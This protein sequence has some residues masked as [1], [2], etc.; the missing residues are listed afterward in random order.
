MLDVKGIH[1]G[2]GQAMI[3]HDIS[4]TVRQGEMVFI[5]GRNGAG[6]T[7]F[8]KSV[9]GLIKPEKGSIFYENKDTQGVSVDKLARQGIRYV[10]QD[11]KVFSQISVRGNI[12]LAA[13][14]AGTDKASSVSKAV[15]IYPEFEKF[16]NAR[17]GNLSGGQR[18][19]LLIAR[20]LVGNPKLLLIDEPT[21]GL[22]AV[23]IEDIVRI[24][25]KMK[26]QD[27]SAIIV[28]QNLSVVSRLADRIYVF[29]E[30][31]IIKEIVTDEITD[32]SEL[33][34]YL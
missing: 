31:N 19:I 4:I 27:V 15:E 18:E 16:L 8:L 25:G 3:L 1:A 2:Y 26:K 32:I 13:Y 11:K 12:E 28:E 29:R 24:L 21:E 5:V 33:E 34:S 9:A 30:G 17:A 14:A 20:A 22:A 10:A 7:T 6:K 23:V